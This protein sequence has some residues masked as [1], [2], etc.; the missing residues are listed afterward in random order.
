MMVNKRFKHQIRRNIEVFI[1]NTIVKSRTTDSHLA[2]LVETFQVLKKF[3]MSLNLTKCTFGVNSRKFLEF[4]VHWRGTNAN[5]KKVQA[6]LKMRPTWSVRE[7][8]QL[9]RQISTLN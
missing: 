7:V 5:P 2:D 8:Q 9:T 4:I 1:D 3:N 6:I